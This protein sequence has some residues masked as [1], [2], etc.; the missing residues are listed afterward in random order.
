MRSSPSLPT[1]LPCNEVPPYWSNANNGD[2]YWHFGG[3][4][5][6]RLPG[7]RSTRLF[8]ASRATHGSESGRLGWGNQSPV[9]S[10]CGLLDFPSH[11][12][13]GRWTRY[14][15]VPSIRDEGVAALREPQGMNS[16]E[17]ANYVPMGSSL[18]LSERSGVGRPN[19]A[20]PRRVRV[21]RRVTAR[22]D[23]DCANPDGMPSAALLRDRPLP[24]AKAGDMQRSNVSLRIP[25]NL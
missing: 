11:S 15:C 3:K 20:V 24:N 10:S 5:H 1:W 23:Q 25:R 12:S 16:P 2:R 13:I 4:S 17:S 7:R 22:S 6:I 9:T 8:P 14:D 21:P 18:P 19:T